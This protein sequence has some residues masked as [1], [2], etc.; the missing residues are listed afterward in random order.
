MLNR[1]TA[2]PLGS[3]TRFASRVL[4]CGWIA[5][6]VAA[7][8]VAYW[9]AL[10]GSFLW[11]DDA[12]VTQPQLRSIQGLSRIWF[13]LGT[14]QQ[15]CPLLH[16][17]FWLQWQLWGDNPFG[18][19]IVNLLLHSAAAILVYL[20]LRK[21]AIPGAWFAMAI[22]AVHPVMVESVAWVS[23]Q[24]NTLSAVF[25]LSSMLSYLHFDQSRRRSYYVAALVLFILGLLSKTVT[26]TLPA[27]ILVIFWWQ[28]GRL[29]WRRDIGPLIPFFSLGAVAG[30]CTAIV[31]REI[32]G[33][34][35][36]SYEIPMV[37]RCLLVGQVVWF[38][39]G[40]LFWPGDLIFIYPRWEP[41][42][43]I[44]WQWLPLLTAAAMTLALLLLRRRYR[45][46]LAGWL[47]FV[48]TLF[49]VLGFFNV[50]PFIYSYVSD[51]FQ[52]LAS[53][54]II[55]PL[56]AGFAVATSALSQS[57]RTAQAMSAPFL[58]LFVTLDRQQCLMYHDI[59][60][61]YRTTIDRNPVCWMAQ[62]NLGLI[63]AKEGRAQQAR[64]YFEM[65]L[66]SKP[67][68]A[69]AH[70]NL[71]AL[72]VNTGQFSEAVEHGQRALQLNQKSAA[73]HCNLANALAGT[74]EKQEAIRHY[75]EALRLN[76][77]FPDAHYNLSLAL[78]DSDPAEAAKH[79]TRAV[80]LQPTFTDAWG[81]LAMAYAQIGRT[82]DAIATAN[83]AMELARQQGQGDVATKLEKW[84][85]SQT[86]SGTAPT[87]NK[88]PASK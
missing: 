25:Y 68:Y 43:T 82:S 3:E 21:L 77:E 6:V 22:F 64:E 78:L 10:H 13:D 62:D 86:A 32:I 72:F 67:D 45:A 65:A 40:K 51:H 36:M 5:L 38:Y 48:G 23:E 7:L 66:R 81:N 39:L 88:A 1:D 30:L 56:A 28:R 20:N 17:A 37:A 61:L 85:A 75:D 33:A 87:Q 53:L 83:K 70:N 2:S 42:P 16:S 54:G 59:V 9:P 19:H 80:E 41:D 58:L 44:W 50:Y 63:F 84:T 26:A 49:P 31:E 29:S 15:Y 46:P 18:Y 60:T 73:A 52:Y 27:A 69:D 35:G 74:G 47:F 76:S 34:K 79:A 11:D 12:H 8:F 4:A 55:V 57:A 24:K 14:T 71:A